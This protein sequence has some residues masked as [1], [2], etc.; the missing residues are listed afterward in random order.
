MFKKWKHL[1]LLVMGVA[2][3][4]S[5]S[6]ES[7]S[8]DD[9][10]RKKSEKDAFMRNLIDSEL[11]KLIEFEPWERGLLWGLEPSTVQPSVSRT[12]IDE[13]DLN[14]L[15]AGGK[16]LSPPGM[17]P[18]D[19]AALRRLISSELKPLATAS[20]RRQPLSTNSRAAHS[21]TVA[22]AAPTF[23]TQ[24]SNL[25]ELSGESLKFNSSEEQDTFDKKSYEMSEFSFDSPEVSELLALKPK[26][27]GSL[28]SSSKFA[29]IPLEDNVNDE[30]RIHNIDFSIPDFPPFAFS[31]DSTS[32]EIPQPA[33]AFVM[34]S[35]FGL[36]EPKK[37]SEKENT[38]N[39]P[40]AVQKMKMIVDI[41]DQRMT[42]SST[43]S[44]SA[45]SSTMSLTLS[46]T[47][48]TPQEVT[49][50]LL[51]GT[52][53]TTMKFIRKTE[54][55][56][57]PVSVTSKM[58][59]GSKPFTKLATR[60]INTTSTTVNAK[61]FATPDPSKD[62]STVE[63]P[64]P[65]VEK[66]N[67]RP[68]ED[69]T[70]S[71]SVKSNLVDEATRTTRLTRIRIP[72]D[73]SEIRGRDEKSA[74]TQE[75]LEMLGDKIEGIDQHMMRTG[76]VGRT[77][78]LRL[79]SVSSEA[80]TPGFSRHR[81]NIPTEKPRQRQLK[82]TEKEPNLHG[83]MPFRRA[84]S[85]LPNL[86]R[87][88]AKRRTKSSSGGFSKKIDLTFDPSPYI[89]TTLFP[90]NG[91]LFRL[92]ITRAE[93]TTEKQDTSTNTSDKAVNRISEDTISTLRSSLRKL[94]ESRR[95]VRSR[96]SPR[97][98]NRGNNL[99][100]T[101]KSSSKHRRRHSPASPKAFSKE[102]QT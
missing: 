100:K 42:A 97:S 48:P 74:M 87:Y 3:A 64:L 14:S 88:G 61:T 85:E 63:P 70:K 82:K 83:E 17:Q 22:F 36:K 21:K 79:G 44:T 18:P 84:V 58:T 77:R 11:S 95:R 13:I 54:T 59:G 27:L 12:T 80:K 53:S 31:E 25:E 47:T 9:I 65:M 89:K 2:T 55:T 37:V 51:S 101:K 28:I 92:K 66:L 90:Q 1:L 29:G 38:F 24:I 72:V 98:K 99:P 57:I 8:L 102:K 76:P 45:T 43:A 67:I 7:S 34:P 68:I 10:K 86:P 73:H 33:Q 78:R 39:I 35:E 69:A 93:S 56:R 41:T 49:K 30:I 50:V 96:T 52:T 62:F 75:M 40:N 94:R 23:Q 15:S 5:L 16:S 4:S 26:Q 32:A 19:V 20:R 46:P 81:P 6:Q 71:T 60:K 91:S